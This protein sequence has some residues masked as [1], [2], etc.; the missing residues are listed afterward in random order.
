[1][2]GSTSS[3]LALVVDDDPASAATLGWLLELFGFAVAIANNGEEALARLSECTPD[4]V[5]ISIGPAAMGVQELTRLLRQHPVTRTVP[6]I[7][8]TGLVSGEDVKQAKEAGCDVVVPKP[9]PLDTLLEE[10][11]RLAA[12][13]R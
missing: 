8:Q 3:P 7:A 10:I 1:V 9:C 2:T 5:T 4:V 11:R 6:V 12:P 13:G